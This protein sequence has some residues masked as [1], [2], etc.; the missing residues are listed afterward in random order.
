MLLWGIFHGR[1]SLVRQGLSGLG[2]GLVLFVVGFAFFEGVLNLGGE[3]GLAP[4]GRQALPIALIAAGVLVVISRL[5]PRR[6][7]QS[8]PQTGWPPQSSPPWSTAP[9]G[10]L[11]PHISDMDTRE[12]RET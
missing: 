7:Q 6:H 10:P 5:L 9:T 12:A 2:V 4:L 1:V 11:G 8:G 3:R